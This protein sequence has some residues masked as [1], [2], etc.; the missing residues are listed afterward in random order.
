MALHLWYLS[1]KLVALSLF[2]DDATA[3]IKEETAKTIRNED[4]VKK[5]SLKKS[6]FH[7]PT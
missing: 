3:S 5:A 6:A 7:L 4:E 1:K 2:D